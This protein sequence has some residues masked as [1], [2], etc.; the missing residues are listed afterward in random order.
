MLRAELYGT[1]FDTLFFVS[2]DSDVCERSSN[3]W[4]PL[5]HG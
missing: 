3:L 4:I 1:K 5:E 2:D